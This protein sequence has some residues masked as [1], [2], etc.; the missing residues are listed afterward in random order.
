M[1]DTITNNL[2][3]NSLQDIY[4]LYEED[5]YITTMIMIYWKSTYTC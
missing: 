3:D 5:N 2:I 1:S 4:H